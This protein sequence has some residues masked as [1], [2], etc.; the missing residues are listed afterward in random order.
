EYEDIYKRDA[1]GNHSHNDV[2]AT[3]SEKNSHLGVRIGRKTQQDLT[4]TCDDYR[5]TLTECIRR[6][7]P[8]GLRGVSIVG[9]KIRHPPVTQRCLVDRPFASAERL[10]VAA[11]ACSGRANVRQRRRH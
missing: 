5:E 10:E 8:N 3:P 6:V 1:A 9:S 4:T 11:G 7:R 2:E